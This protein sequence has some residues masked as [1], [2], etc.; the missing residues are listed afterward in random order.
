MR[1]AK[2]A[3]SIEASNDADMARF[4]EQDKIRILMLLLFQGPKTK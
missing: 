3:L 4:N 1:D 2:E